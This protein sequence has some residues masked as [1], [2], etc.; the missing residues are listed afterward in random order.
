[1]LDLA[2]TPKE[3]VTGLLERWQYGD[4]SALNALSELLYGELRRLAQ[5]YVKQE[6]PD[7]TLQATALVNEAYIRLINTELHYTSK[8]HFMSIAGRML[9]RILV[10]Y[11]RSANAQKRG[12]AHTCITLDEGA[13]GEKTNQANIIQLN[14]ALEQLSRQDERKAQVVELNFFAGLSAEE[15][16]PILNIS[17][18][19]AERDLKFA[20]AWLLQELR[21]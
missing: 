20:K 8:H 16:A 1:M 18:R 3:D 10:D 17:S 12:R 7:H 5:Y 21:A 11:A 9:R 6:R 19:T 13:L 2:E 15:L 14:D 4:A